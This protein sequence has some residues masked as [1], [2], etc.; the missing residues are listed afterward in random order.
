MIRYD[1]THL[2][3][4]SGED[5]KRSTIGLVFYPEPD[6][7]PLFNFKLSQSFVHNDGTGETAHEFV[8]QCAIGF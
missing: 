1:Q 5:I 6:L 2:D 8:I 4:G 7:N 3:D